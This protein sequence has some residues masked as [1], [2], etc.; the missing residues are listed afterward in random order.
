MQ[1]LLVGGEDP[2]GWTNSVEALCLDEY[3]WTTCTP[4]PRP[5]QGFALTAL[6]GRLYLLGGTDDDDI[7][8]S[9]VEVFDVASGMWLRGVPSMLHARTGAA[10]MTLFGRVYALGGNGGE[11]EGYLASA[12]RLC[13][14]LGWERLP[15][16]H[17]ARADAAAAACAAGRLYAAGG[18]N[19]GEILRVAEVYDAERGAWQA[20]PDMMTPRARCAAATIRTMV[21]VMGGFNDEVYLDTVEKYDP[22][23]SHWESVA[24]MVLP[25]SAAGAVQC[26]GSVYVFGGW[27]AGVLLDLVERYDP[28]PSG[29]KAPPLVMFRIACTFY[30]RT[31]PGAR[32][33]GE[34]T[35]RAL[36]WDSS[37]ASTTLLLNAT[38]VLCSDGEG[39]HSTIGVKP[40]VD[41]HSSFLAARGGSSL[42]MV[43]SEQRCFVCFESLPDAV[44]LECGHAG[45][46][47]ECATNLLRRQGGQGSCPI[48][49]GGISCILKLRPEIGLEDWCKSHGLAPAGALPL[50]VCRDAVP[51]QV[52]GAW[53]TLPSMAT[54]RADFGIAAVWCVAAMDEES[55]EHL[56]GEEHLE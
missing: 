31:C 21:F 28:A 30:S 32:V 50:E 36:A 27:N 55:A 2:E 1:V 48:C 52:M 20:L 43:E 13:P 22:E 3:T 10:A 46:C 9:S 15:P 11:R 37:V 34:D 25:R 8:L 12:E 44:L 33:T 23:I 42:D 4:L 51:V 19:G 45:M 56:E 17:S 6:D 38:P 7:E 26:H 49:R 47:V 41:R 14:G 53:S 24:S 16:L 5:R 18:R 35:V 54:P 40:C 29:G 39:G